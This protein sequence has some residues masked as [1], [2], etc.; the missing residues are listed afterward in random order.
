MIS[1][2]IPFI[3][4]LGAAGMYF[5]YIEPTYSGPVAEL[6]KN[7][8]E[9]DAALL[10]AG[11]FKEKEEE[12][13]AKRAA[14]PAE[15]LARLDAF[16]PDNVDNVQLIIDLDS[17]ASRSGV[18]LSGFNISPPS[19]DAVDPAATVTDPSNTQ[20]TES[21]DLSLTVTGSY[22]AFKTFL[23]SIEQSL[24]LLDVTSISLQDS[25]TGVYTYNLSLRLYWLR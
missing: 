6:R 23:A 9:L 17:L 20:A 18:Q 22:A 19:A 2:L 11:E 14:I 25:E 24:R 7:M 5:G 3:L 21:L 15:Q 12:L 16:L 8:T 1:R 13:R 10:A 4:V